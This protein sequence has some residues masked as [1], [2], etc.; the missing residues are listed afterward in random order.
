MT[1]LANLE[2]KAVFGFFEEIASIPH[3]SGNIEA[4][5]DYLVEFAKKRKL[6]YVQD[7]VKNVII[8]KKATAGYEEEK[9]IIIQGHMDM[10]CVKNPDCKKDMTKEA[11]DLAVEGDFVYA[12]ETSLGGDDGIAVAYALALLNS[13]VIAHPDL[14]V[15]LTVDEETGMGGAHNLDMSCFKGRQLL[16]IDSEDEGILLSSCA[17]GA[18]LECMIP[19]TYEERSGTAFQVTITGLSGGHS[20]LDIHKG[21]GNTNCLYGRMLFQLSK[22]LELGIANLF[23]GHKDNAIPSETRGLL[24]VG[25]TDILEFLTKIKEFETILQKEYET[26]DPGL[27]IVCKQM[28]KG[29]IKVLDSDSKNRVVSSLIHQH[30]GVWAMSQKIEGLVESS[31]N[32]GILRIDDRQ[33]IL[34]FSIRSSVQT[35]KEYM[36]E[37]IVNQ[38]SMLGGKVNINSQYP[39]WE[40]KT[41]S[42]L[43][44]KMTDVYQRM[45]GEQM[46]VEAVHAGLECGILSA[47]CPELDCVSFGPQMFH[48][49]TPKEKLCISSTGRVWN[50]LVAILAE[51]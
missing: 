48:I 33:V 40:Y 19:V 49:H 3:G 32:L 38:I 6:D 44:E 5:S 16:N 24:V 42:K 36:K 39:A 12:K 14:E 18:T 21:R 51:K 30:C 34:H 10:V 8:Y 23:G 41:E 20:G 9:P 35:V 37:L 47:K 13:N 28:E 2:P 25:E 1:V 43:R 17:G 29:V 50:Y 26:S 45:Y 31:A 27:Q 4:I 46:K 7:S 22:N 15:V 11:I